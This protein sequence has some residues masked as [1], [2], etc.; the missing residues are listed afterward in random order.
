VRVNRIFVRASSLA[1]LLTALLLPPNIASAHCDRMDGPIVKAAQKALETGN[2]DLILIWVQKQDDTR[3]FYPQLVF[4][5]PPSTTS[6][7]TRA[8]KSRIKVTCSVGVFSALQI[9]LPQTVAR[10]TK[11]TFPSRTSI[12]H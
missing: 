3:S 10:S 8:T 9:P 5:P 7:A 12:L 11:C 4:P 2:V 1:V 6:S